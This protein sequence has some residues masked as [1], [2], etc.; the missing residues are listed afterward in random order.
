MEVWLGNFCTGTA[1]HADS[2]KAQM[3]DRRSG[4]LVMTGPVSHITAFCLLPRHQKMEPTGN[5]GLAE[6]PV[7]G[8]GSTGLSTGPAPEDGAK[9]QV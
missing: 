5:E 9:G 2:Y 8:T 3:Q 1:T 4:P 6:V 7:K